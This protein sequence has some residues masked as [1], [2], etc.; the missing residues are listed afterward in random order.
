MKRSRSGKSAGEDAA[1]DGSSSPSGGGGGGGS[2]SVA[3]GGDDGELVRLRSA[4]W[5][6]A[7]EIAYLKEELE[8]LHV[9]L[10][11]AS[12]LVGTPEP[13]LGGSSHGGCE[14]GGGGA[15]G[16]CRGSRTPGA[17]MPL[18]AA[19]ASPGTE[20]SGGRPL[21]VA[22][23][24]DCDKAWP[25]SRPDHVHP[26]LAP[27]GSPSAAG[28]GHGVD[29]DQQASSEADTGASSGCRGDR[30]FGL[31]INRQPQVESLVQGSGVVADC[32]RASGAAAPAE[33]CRDNP[34]TGLT[35]STREPGSRSWTRWPLAVG[36]SAGPTSPALEEPTPG[37]SSEGD[38][39]DECK[40]SSSC[41]QQQGQGGDNAG[42]GGGSCGGGRGGDIVVDGVLRF[43]ST[44][45]WRM[46]ADLA[47]GD[48]EKKKGRPHV[49]PGALHYGAFLEECAE[50]APGVWL[51]ASVLLAAYRAW[52]ETHRAVPDDAVIKNLQQQVPFA[53][54]MLTPTQLLTLNADAGV[55]A[56]AGAGAGA[57]AAT[58]KAY[59]LAQSM[60]LGPLGL[61]LRKKH[62]HCGSRLRTVGMNY[63]GISL[64][65]PPSPP[66]PPLSQHL[67]VHGSPPLVDPRLPGTAQ[68][69][70]SGLDE[71][72][73]TEGFTAAIGVSP[74]ST[75]G[76]TWQE[77]QDCPLGLRCSGGGGDD[78]S[79][80]LGV[81]RDGGVHNL[82]AGGC[83]WLE[84]SPDVAW[85]KEPS[86]SQLNLSMSCATPSLHNRHTE[87]AVSLPGPSSSEVAA[88]QG[89]ALLGSWPPTEG[90]HEQ[91]SECQSDVPLC[92]LD[93]HCQTESADDCTHGAGGAAILQ[94]MPSPLRGAWAA[95]R[96]ASV[97][98]QLRLP[99]SQQPPCSEL[100]SVELDS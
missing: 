31:D 20:L 28:C 47:C 14:T 51:S 83:S 79:H 57:D 40:P 90:C 11:K 94:V 46:L 63:Y 67:P 86:D 3:A 23:G 82:A 72:P 81:G 95:G 98:E 68:L 19:A 22:R 78:D 84:H 33:A 35:A 36:S 5:R 69:V 48:Y 41:L 16:A 21:P 89:E 15:S 99:L 18:A 96:S 64:R 54:Q 25:S 26:S 80:S 1:V 37:A 77:L 34:A 76:G 6:Q 66:L 32:G 92:P 75:G 2:A 71:E 52:A 7:R 10:L 29:S 100:E 45:S 39:P 9:K 30:S 74:G 91:S 70:A 27:S 43:M 62:F 55:G 61:D 8:E 38:V 53:P 49:V 87:V 44:A 50:W 60:V 88:L 59:A 65:Q 58:D 85:R 24:M 13:R 12:R 42:G 73:P 17:T 56:G 97:G 4:N 93:D